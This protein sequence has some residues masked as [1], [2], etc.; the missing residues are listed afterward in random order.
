[1]MWHLIELGTL[2]ASSCLWE[3][4]EIQSPMPTKHPQEIDLTFPATMTLQGPT[5]LK[6]QDTTSMISTPA[7]QKIAKFL[8]RAKTSF[9]GR[10]M[11]TLL[12]D[13]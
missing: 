2:R 8:T 12:S 10:W 3:I 13:W 4:W 6:S 7:S 11:S 5:V 1:M 9:P